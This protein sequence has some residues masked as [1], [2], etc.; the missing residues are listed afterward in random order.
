MKSDRFQPSW[1]TM[2]LVK[3]MHLSKPHVLETNPKFVVPMVFEDCC[4][5]GC[6]G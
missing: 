6:Q 5:G 4:L 1:L 2:L 3:W